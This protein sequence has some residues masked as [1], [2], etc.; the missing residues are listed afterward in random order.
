MNQEDLEIDL[1]VFENQLVAGK[2]LKSLVK[3]SEACAE[4]QVQAWWLPDDDEFITLYDTLVL[5]YMASGKAEQNGKSLKDVQVG[6]SF[7][8]NRM[9]DFL[10][11]TPQKFLEEE[12]EK[13][14][15]EEGSN[16]EKKIIAAKALETIQSARS[17]ERPKGR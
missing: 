14:I 2:A 6:Q 13:L 9:V 15:F 7:Y 5:D 3:T 8:A 16:G 4:H 17:T 12:Y 1:E 11:T 10:K